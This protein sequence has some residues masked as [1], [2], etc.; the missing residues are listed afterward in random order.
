M[1]NVLNYRYRNAFDT[2]NDYDTP[3]VSTGVA[4]RVTESDIVMARVYRE[5]KDGSPDDTG[6]ALGSGTSFKTS[7]LEPMTCAGIAV[8]AW[9]RAPRRRSR[10]DTLI[11]L[12]S[13]KDNRQVTGFGANSVH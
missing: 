5:W 11:T 3:E 4:L 6:L 9:T 10:L 12:A 2:D 1:W 7:T 13:P 8:Q